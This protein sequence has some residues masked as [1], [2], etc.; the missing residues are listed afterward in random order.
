MRLRSPA[1]EPR[2]NNVTSVR[3][4]MCISVTSLPSVSPYHPAPQLFVLYYVYVIR[5]SR[6]DLPPLP[7]EPTH[8]PGPR[9]IPLV[10]THTLLSPTTQTFWNHTTHTSMTLP[11]RRRSVSH[12]SPKRPFRWRSADTRQPWRPRQ[13]SHRLKQQRCEEEVECRIAGRWLR[14]RLCMILSRSAQHEWKS[15]LLS[16]AAWQITWTQIWPSGSQLRTRTRLVV[17]K[18]QMGL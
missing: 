7:L 8:S 15:S 6:L 2:P 14:M 18:G 12:D 1:V 9:T 10:L 5:S 3:V 17:I 13:T 4:S 11:W 16:A